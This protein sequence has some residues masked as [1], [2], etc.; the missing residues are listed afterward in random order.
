[1]VSCFLRG[2]V[3]ACLVACLVDWFLGLVACLVVW[4]G[5]WLLGSEIGLLGG[6]FAGW[7]VVLCHDGWF[8]SWL[9]GEQPRADPHNYA[10]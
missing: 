1:M 7:L 9:L 4:L 2:L 10:R 8:V 5:V 6:R 3:V